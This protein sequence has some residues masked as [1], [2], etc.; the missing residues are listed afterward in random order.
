MNPRYEVT[1]PLRDGSPLRPPQRV[2]PPSLRDDDEKYNPLR[3]EYN[4]HRYEYYNS[5]RYEYNSLRYEYNPLRYVL[6][7]E[8]NP[9]RSKRRRY[10]MTSPLRF[11]ADVPSRRC[12]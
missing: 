7:Y 10:E 4:L 3:L 11:F 2:Q 1:S 8:M 9:R 5:L 12:R 6:R